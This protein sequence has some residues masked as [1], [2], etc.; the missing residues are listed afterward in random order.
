MLFAAGVIT[1]ATWKWY[2]T[3]RLPCKCVKSRKS[4][5][6]ASWSPEHNNFFNLK[7]FIFTESGQ[8]SNFHLE[9]RFPDA[10][11]S[12]ISA[13]AKT[14]LFLG[15][16]LKSVDLSQYGVIHVGKIEPWR[17]KTWLLDILNNDEGKLATSDT[18]AL[19][20]ELLQELSEGCHEL[21]DLLAPVFNRFP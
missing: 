5:K 21:L 3:H 9:F 13:S 6:A 18:S 12:P 7:H 19:T 17:R 2:A 8:I 14:F 20:P 10:D 16:L 15:L 4:L 11:L 1:P